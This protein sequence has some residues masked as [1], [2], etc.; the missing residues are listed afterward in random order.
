MKA[1][2]CDKCDEIEKGGQ[3]GANVEINLLYVGIPSEVHLCQRC[4]K[5]FLRWLKGEPD[6]DGPYP[7]I[8]F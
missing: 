6:D 2:I 3:Y 5:N 1:I 8:S 4:T 7:E